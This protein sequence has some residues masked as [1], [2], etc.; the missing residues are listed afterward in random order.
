MVI[1]CLYM[2][3]GTLAYHSPFI[4]VFIAAGEVGPCPVALRMQEPM[5]TISANLSDHL[6]GSKMK[7]I[8]GKSEHSEYTVG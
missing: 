1:F 2:P 3:S 4:G 5:A 7:P 8:C 6:C